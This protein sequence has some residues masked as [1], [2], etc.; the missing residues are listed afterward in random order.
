MPIGALPGTGWCPVTCRIS[1]LDAVVPPLPLPNGVVVVDLFDFSS[2]LGAGVAV[3]HPCPLPPGV[4]ENFTGMAEPRPHHIPLVMGI[5]VF[6]SGRAIIIFSA[7]SR[8]GWSK[9]SWA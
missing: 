5:A 2:F 6:F 7:G 9:P 8:I 3:P 1:D 4:V